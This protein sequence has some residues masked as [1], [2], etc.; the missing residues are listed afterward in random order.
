MI[1]QFTFMNCNCSVIN[2]SG[3][4]MDG[5]SRLGK[6]SEQIEM[7]GF[8]RLGKHSEQIELKI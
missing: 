3:S 5:F 1:I 2:D 6:H 4:M 8:S 7:D